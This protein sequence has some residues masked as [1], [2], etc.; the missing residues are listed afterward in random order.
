[1]TKD[2]LKKIIIQY[3]AIVYGLIL[4]IGLVMILCAT[5]VPGLRI[6]HI[7]RYNILI[8]IGCSIVSS[9][10][11]TATLLLLL[12]D[13]SDERHELDEWG[14]CKIYSERNHVR[15]DSKQMP[16]H[17]LY[18][19]AF[20]LSHF[21]GANGNVGKIASKIRGGLEV[22]I[23][24]MSPDSAFLMEQERI[25][26][27]KGI[28][29]DI[30]DLIK[31]VEAVKKTCRENPKGH[32]EL[33]FY[34]SLPLDFFCRADGKVYVGPYMPGQLSGETITY[35]YDADSKGGKY[36]SEIF[37]KVWKCDSPIK[38]SLLQEKK[39]CFDQDLAINEVLKYFCK[40]LQGNLIEKVVGVVAIFKN[41]KRRTF[42]SC[43]KLHEDK[44]VC[45]E[46]GEGTVGK[47]VA[48]NMS[49]GAFN[50]M[51]WSDYQ[52]MLMISYRY[53][54]RK[55]TVMKERHDVKKL[56]KNEDTK[57]ILAFPLFVD[58][59]QI[60]ALTFDFASLP[61]DY[62]GKIK[63]LSDVECGK[64]LSDNLSEEL[65]VLFTIAEQCGKIVIHLLGNAVSM[66]Y[67]TL[68]EEEW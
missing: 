35:C 25:E 11:V 63:E 41:D 21:R 51:L 47:L 31:W 24:T 15:I 17:M 46:K 16:K 66:K 65:I 40:E 29:K 42:F 14:I 57:A 22:R 33:K 12:P 2:R 27:N 52:N 53:E 4:L 13:L 8:G 56:D 64:E 1:M 49:G 10:I 58:N 3:K 37:E 61:K 18:F 9:V 23:V 54:A 67:K 45:H 5:L 60:G 34:D 48:L 7:N 55:K 38:V 36:Y 30:E 20:G 44:H 32:I 50:C 43:N 26:N 59:Q 68:Y 6:D 19:M 39:L 62:E 28:K